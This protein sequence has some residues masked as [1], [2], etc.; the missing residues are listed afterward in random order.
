MEFLLEVRQFNQTCSFKLS[1]GKGYGH[2]A[3]MPF[4]AI[5][6]Q[7]YQEWSTAYQGY[8]K[9]KAPHQQNRDLGDHDDPN[10]GRPGMSA[11]IA[12]AQVNWERQ[13]SFAENQLVNAFCDWLRGR[14]LHGIRKTLSA[15]AAQES[16]PI[17]LLVQCEDDPSIVP[18]GAD[19]FFLAKLPWESFGAD[20]SDRMPIHVLRTTGQRPVVKQRQRR[21]RLRV[22]A[23]F[24][25]DTGLDFKAERAAIEQK[26]KPI[27]YVQFEGYN[28][29][30]VT[31]QKNLKTLITQAIEDPQGWDILF[32]AGHS[33]DGFGGEVMLAPGYSALINEFEDSLKIARDR[34]LQFAL[35]NSC[36]GCA[37]AESLISYG[38]SHVVVMRER[39]SN[40]VAQVFFQAFAD[41]LTKLQDV[42][43]AA[44]GATQA[45]AVKA[46]EQYQYPSAYLLPS[47]YAY[48]E[49]KPLKPP[50]FNWRVVLSLLKPTSR[51]AIVL[52]A[53]VIF[54]CH[55]IIQN[56]LTDWRQATQGSYRKFV[57][58][59]WDKVH[60]PTM[61][62]T[63]IL[64]IKVDDESKVVNKIIDR[65]Y[66]ANLMEKAI[67]LNI[68]TIGLDYVLNAPMPGKE[69][70]QQAFN[71]RKSN[72]FVFGASIK[73]GGVT[74]S[75]TVHPKGRID[76]D[77][78]VN[79]GHDKP[80]PVFLARTIG[81]SGQDKKLRPF[82]HEIICQNTTNCKLLDQRAYHQPIT[83]VSR[84]FGQEWFNPWIDYS[85]PHEGV[86]K[87]VSSTEFLQEPAP[88]QQKIA[89]LVPDEKI[90][91][92]QLPITHL[93]SKTE[94]KTENNKEMTGGE[95]HAYMLYNLLSKGL[96]IPFP[97]LW[98]IGI[99]GIISKLGV[100]WLQRR[101][102]ER[103]VDHRGWL[104]L[105]VGIPIV[106]CVI[107]LQTYIGLH[108][109]IPVL[110]PVATYFSYVI[111]HWLQQRK[112][113]RRQNQLL[114][115]V[116][117]K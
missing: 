6:Q 32:F 57:E 22:L 28:I 51:E 92:F 56:T 4:P 41:R 58:V 55:P 21:S 42:Q 116:M 94:S 93:E 64:L 90:D 67:E 43:M 78:D 70:V 89:L 25:D 112:V 49:V 30:P 66:I 34:G 77:I 38:L 111:P 36:R 47:I 61:S 99:V 83:A 114:N 105:L 80:Y 15:Y 100:F 10:R 81:D 95:I 68:E 82:P 20:L 96:I 86:Y 44:L 9:S 97:D 117:I 54:S 37:I 62:A 75:E 65:G 27:A 72:Q 5:L 23:I 11:T 98:M 88:Y 87:L 19:N 84:W 59:L 73:L 18:V 24:G 108:I 12:V 46:K 60:E 91:G 74:N 14:E 48:S 40:Q 16:A 52:I 7:Y 35:F 113:K 106:A 76:A 26:L 31:T 33:D 102:K 110:F 101:P 50:P 71:H 1:W 53:L 13:L 29:S 3:R 85:I 69:K 8:Y 63:P 2:D 107:S 104:I 103:S 109:A 45:L 79:G 39:V 115:Q 17:V